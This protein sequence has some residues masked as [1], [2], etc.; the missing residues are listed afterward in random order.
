MESLTRWAT[1]RPVAITVIAAAVFI[2][3]WT[4]WRKLPLDLL[5]DLQSPTIVVSIRSGDRPPAEM[6]RVYAEL[7]EQRLFAV[8][9]ISE[10]GQV[11]R[12][13]R[14]ITTVVFDWDTD[15]DFA[16][17]DVEK[18]VGPIQSD[19]DVDE[20]LVR[21]LDP[22][23]APVLVLGLLAREGG[24]DLAEL[25]RIARRQVATA[26]ERLD[27]VAEVRVTGG[28]EKEVRVQVDRYRL[29]AHGLTLADLETRLRAAN[30][31]INAGTLEEGQRV[32]LVRGLAR[33]QRPQD[34][35]AVVL[36]YGQDV[37]GARVA[38]RISDVA[39]IEMVDREVNHLVRV[40]GREG[41]GLA[42]YKEAGA[43][44][45]RMS[46]AVREGLASMQGDLPG[47]EVRLVS[48]EAAL[49]EDSLAELQESALV[50]LGLAMLVIVFF[51]RAAGPTITVA[52]SVPVSMLAALFLMHVGG[53]S[54]NI[55]TLGGLALGA[56]MLI[57]NA[58]VVVESIF[59]RLA[60]GEEPQDAAALGAAEVA[61]PITASTLTLCAVFLPIVFA[62]GLAARLVTGLSFS[63]VASVL[64][65][66]VVAILLIPAIS[67]WLLP[68]RGARPVDPGIGRVERLVSVLLRQPLLVTTL[69]LLLAA[70]AVA[71]LI[72]LGSELLPPADPRQFSLRLVGPPGQRVEATAAVV[73]SVEE[74]LKQ[75][76]GDDWR[77][78][79]SE[80]GRLPE[81]DRLIREEQTEENTARIIVR[82]AAGGRSGQQV[83]LA[84][85]PVIESL[86]A[87]ELS[88]EIG[89]SALARALGT[90][91]PP[92]LIEISGQSLD[93][94]RTA[95]GRMRDALAERQELWNVRS[96]F[97]GG[98]PE[99]RLELDRTLADGLGI[100]LET[101]AGTLEAALDG[102]AVTAL[103]I[104]DEEHRIVLRLPEVRRDEL[105][106]LPLRS[107]AGVRCLVRDIATMRTQEGAR[108]IFR[109]DQR[110]VARVTAQIAPRS[111]FPQ[112]MRAAREAK[113]SVDMPPGLHARV[114][115]EEEERAAAFRELGLAG[116]LALL[117][118]FMVLA[119][120]FE[121]LI[122]PLTVVIA[123]PLSLIGVAL[124]LVP[125][126]RPIGVMEML[127]MIV[128]AGVAVNDSILLIDAARQ[129][130][131][132]G[133]PRRAA[134]A[135]AAGL[136]LR[137]ILMTMLTSVLALLPL[138][139]GT[140]EA[141][142]LRSPL[143][144][145]VIG[146]LVS[147]MLA[148]LF[149]IPC[150]YLLLDRLRPA[151]ARRSG[152]E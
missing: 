115:G 17:V 18:A 26:L 91:G 130:M 116:G 38:V 146:G 80:V 78:V 3:G 53:H 69:A 31:D 97:E 112:A 121:S 92:V 51:L 149:V 87:L 107:P 123:V 65:S 147:S 74:V 63:V 103:T 5:P 72:H 27:G 104:G 67:G 124:I 126:G 106:D 39:E 7:V 137:P 86:G 132:A 56:G 134:L 98:P 23:Q 42:I 22:R 34:V 35:A 54:L 144:L 82:L 85:T 108:E 75:A 2:L 10:I 50:G 152:F 135:R 36:R 99:L 89:T 32:Y 119:G 148:S 90:S 125:L 58:I 11:A 43:N 57:D 133:L 40:D 129:Q 37:T 13:G 142:R 100:S 15:M 60:A 113:D 68:R 140:G 96:S 28:R 151:R 111:D 131:A 46:R 8:R 44:T 14:L 76:A 110:R 30:V 21:H 66:M 95:A 83:A 143:A 79:L 81:D 105:L 64:A 138:A 150:M 77:A 109:R 61:G 141:A 101:V 55:M 45:V 127:G 84:A 136:R 117:L 73:E 19:P 88:W 49:I 70:G 12:T 41:V 6:E 102:R 48:D 62:R 25:R 94:L 120:T 9:G 1:R 4:A 139:L 24:P 122:H 33:F 29:E 20:V 93:D 47:I 145:T 16:L 52:L 59:R 118:I 114:A 128:L 71:G